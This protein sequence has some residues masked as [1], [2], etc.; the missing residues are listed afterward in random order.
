[1]PTTTLQVLNYP[2][3]GTQLIT[4]LTSFG[5]YIS[6]I[7]LESPTFSVYFSKSDVDAAYNA[8]VE[9]FYGNCVGI[10]IGDGAGNYKFYFDCLVGGG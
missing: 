1:M 2:N 7:T 10:L 4:G 9:K 8:R 3:T 6:S 5:A